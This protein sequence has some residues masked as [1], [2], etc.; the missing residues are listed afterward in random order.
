MGDARALLP[1]LA[2]ASVDF[3]A[4]DPPYNVQ[5][6]MTMAG[7]KLAETHANRRTDYAMVA[8]SPRTSPT[9]PT[10]PAYLD[11]MSEVLCEVHRVLRPGRY[12][13][14]I[15]RDAYQDGRYLFTA[16]DLAARGAAAGLVPKGDIT[17]YQAGT[18]LRPYG[19]PRS[20]VPNIVHQHILVLRKAPEPR[21]ARPKAGRPLG[22]AELP[23]VLVV[24]AASRPRTRRAS[25]RRR[26]AVQLSAAAVDES[27][28]TSPSVI[29][30]S[31]P[32]R[33]SGHRT[34]QY[35]PRF[36][37]RTTSSPSSRTRSR[38]PGPRRDARAG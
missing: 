16:A 21:A 5:L 38:C 28:T 19:Y 4:T 26:P 35:V 3:V 2:A 32:S 6:P 31:Q 15:V 10:T 20:F 25:G 34:R 27:I 36:S 8:T 7:G 22:L 1:T 30:C 17:W 11:A 13:V 29:L 9:S 18:R 33:P 12:A 23:A 14:L 24:G 37:S